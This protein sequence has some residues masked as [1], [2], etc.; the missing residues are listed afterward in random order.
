M[1]LERVPS[2]AWV[3]GGKT[4][5]SALRDYIHGD[6][7]WVMWGTTERSA[8]RDYIHG[9]T[10]W[11]PDEKPGT[12]ISIDEITIQIFDALDTCM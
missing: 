7:A 11:D 4:E 6:T 3:M 1:T 5:R 8:L 9:D 2:R 12:I 10:A